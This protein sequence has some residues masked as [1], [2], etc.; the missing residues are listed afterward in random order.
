MNTLTKPSG[1]LSKFYRGEK[2]LG[3]SKGT[4]SLSSL[5]LVLPPNSSTPS[6]LNTNTM[7]RRSTKN[8][9]I[10]LSVYPILTIIL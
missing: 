9:K 1:K 2:P 4:I 5:I 10:S 8:V 7:I 3:S 6:K